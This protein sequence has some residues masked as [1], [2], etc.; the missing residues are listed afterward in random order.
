MATIDDLIKALSDAPNLIGKAQF[1]KILTN[2]DLKY[3]VESTLLQFVTGKAGHERD[4]Y[5]QEFAEAFT[6]GELQEIFGLDV[7]GMLI[8]VKN[9]FSD[10]RFKE[11][12]QDP[13]IQRKLYLIHLLPEV[14][15]KAR[16]REDILRWDTVVKDMIVD[17]AQSEDPC[18][19]ISDPLKTIVRQSQS[20]KMLEKDRELMKRVRGDVNERIYVFALSLDILQDKTS[21]PEEL[22]Q[23]YNPLVGVLNRYKEDIGR[24]QYLPSLKN[25]ISTQNNPDALTTFRP[26][27]SR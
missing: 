21:K 18:A 15:R 25:F 17:Y 6:G 7:Y 22:E 3:Q 23:W 26:T 11:V 10:P 13:E 20:L 1:V 4:P 9:C 16:K 27:M 19:Y 24:R 12:H 14:L 8:T 5:Y 2:G